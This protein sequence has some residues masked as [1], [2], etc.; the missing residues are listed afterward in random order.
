MALFRRGRRLIGS[1]MRAFSASQVSAAETAGG[2]V[3]PKSPGE[4]KVVAIMGGDYGHNPIFPELFVRGLFG[5]LPSWRIIFVQASRFFTPGLIADADLLITSRHMRPDDIDF[6]PDGLVD[7][8][9]KG[10]LLWTD[11]N[12][13]A[14]VA[15]IRDRGMG[16]LAMHNTVSSGNKQIEDLLGVIPIPHNEIQPLWAH[17]LNGDHPITSGMGTFF[18]PLDEQFGAV[19]KSSYTTM[20]FQTTGIHDKRITV[21]GWC[22]E[23]GRGRIVGLL[24]GHTRNTYA[25]P[26]FQEILWRAAHWAMNRNIP[27]F[28]GAVN[29]LG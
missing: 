12:A 6:R 5:S 4:T 13:A 22:R 2:V 7:S 3:M 19:V 10:A 28:P 9:G 16:F 18:L 15:N 20:L 14:I 27:R 8:A 21:G 17:D 11:E 26:E 23:N 1:S 29:A 25:I 24:P